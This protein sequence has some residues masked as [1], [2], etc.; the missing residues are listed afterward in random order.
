MDS[1]VYLCFTDYNKAFKSITGEMLLK[2][3]KCYGIPMNIVRTL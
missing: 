3:M 1:S 2:I